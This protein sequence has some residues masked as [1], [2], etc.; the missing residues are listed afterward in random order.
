MITAIELPPV[1][2]AARSMY[3]K[4]RDRASYAFALA[5]AAVF[6]GVRRAGAQRRAAGAQASPAI[7]PPQPEPNVT[8]ESVK[9]VSVT[10][11]NFRQLAERQ[12]AAARVALE[13]LPD[14]AVRQTLE[15]LSFY[16]VTRN[17]RVS[18]P[19]P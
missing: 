14:D 9:P 7:Q 13:C 18:S 17:A 12:A 2:A 3:L 6:V 11:V 15:R 19:P 10:T 5:S 16:A 1:K 8:T 4:V